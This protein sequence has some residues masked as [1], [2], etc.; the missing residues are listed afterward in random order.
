M[1]RASSAIPVISLATTTRC[2]C[3]SCSA[4]RQRRR[5]LL[6]AGHA[7][8]VGMPVAPAAV[9]HQALAPLHSLPADLEHIQVL[10]EV[11]RALWVV[12]PDVRDHRLATSIVQLRTRSLYMNPRTPAGSAVTEAGLDMY[13]QQKGRVSW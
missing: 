9:G 5:S 4:A 8:A 10:V 1:E 11:Q 12:P 7:G 13:V 6:P 2:S 3:I